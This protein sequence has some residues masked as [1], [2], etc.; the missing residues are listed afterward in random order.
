MGS[1]RFDK[2]KKFAVNFLPARA[3]AVVA[4]GTTILK[5]AERAGVYINSVCGGEGA[6]V[7]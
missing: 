7:K 3:T 1:Q 6:C 5:A 4:E 2:M